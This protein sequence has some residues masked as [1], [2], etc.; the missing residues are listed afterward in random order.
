MPQHFIL[1]VLF[2][3]GV[4]H[5]TQTLVPH[6]RRESSGNVIGRWTVISIQGLMLLTFITASYEFLHH[7]NPS[8]IYL[9]ILGFA[10]L[11]GKIL[12]KRRCLALLENFYSLYIEV[13]PGQKLVTSGPYAI[14]RHPCFLS[15]I[16]EVFA[17]CLIANSWVTMAVMGPIITT[18]YL[19]RIRM[20]ECVL[21]MHYE[22]AYEK[23]MRGV[24]ALIPGLMHVRPI[25]RKLKYWLSRQTQ[26][27]VE[28]RIITSTRSSLRT[29]I[30]HR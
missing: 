11:I 16:I 1:L 29:Q 14:V 22:D 17:I 2:F 30:R 10:L 6:I 19:V 28:R 27:S 5:L 26:H 12:L 25:I 8:Y 9:Q 23:Y 21:Q 7:G 20:E 3:S 4:L 15:S 24:P 13:R 18:L